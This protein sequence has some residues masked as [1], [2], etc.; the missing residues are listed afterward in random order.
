MVM[1]HAAVRNTQK[2]LS[3]GVSE[4]Q[5]VTCGINSDQSK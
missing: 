1:I 2:H 4:H 3:R 5:K